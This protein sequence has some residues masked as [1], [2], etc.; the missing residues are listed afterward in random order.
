MSPWV[1]KCAHSTQPDLFT[2]QNFPC[3]ASYGAAPT[4]LLVHLLKLSLCE[5]RRLN[6][7]QFGQARV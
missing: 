3:K 7:G 4:A 2:Q 6:R 5:R 1:Y